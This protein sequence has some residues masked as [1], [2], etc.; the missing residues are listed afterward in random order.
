V[1][2]RLCRARIVLRDRLR[3][4]EATPATASR[5]TRLRSAK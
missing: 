3:E 1:M 2:S 4:D 5:V